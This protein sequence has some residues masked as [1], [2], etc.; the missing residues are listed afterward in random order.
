MPDR[1]RISLEDVVPGGVKPTDHLHVEVS[2]GTCSRCR[3]R[4]PIGDVPLMLWVRGGHDLY[5]FCSLCLQ[6]EPPAAPER[7][8]RYCC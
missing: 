6:A 4:P 7:A 2:D 1:S 8:P 5:I 3:E